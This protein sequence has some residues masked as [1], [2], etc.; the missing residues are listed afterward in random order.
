KYVLVV[1]GH[2]GE[3]ESTL[4]KIADGEFKFRF[5]PGDH[6]IFSCKTIPTPTNIENRQA[7]EAKLKKLH[8]RIFKDVHES[9]HAARED[10]RDLINIVKPKHII[11]AH[12][13]GI[14]KGALAELAVEMGYKLGNNVHLMKDGDRLRI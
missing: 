4:S 9:G 13:N 8:L 1:T 11:P 14:M 10:L 12:G 2:Q 7:L 3:P 5:D 6:V